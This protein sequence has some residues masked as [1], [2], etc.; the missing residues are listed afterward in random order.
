MSRISMVMFDLSGTTVKDDTGVRDCLYKAAVEFNL[1]TTPEDILFHMGTNKIHL[2]QYLI[3][4]SKGQQINFKDF[5]KTKDPQTYEE[6]VKI[7]E[8]YQEIMVKHYR[9]NV[10]EVPGASD[11]FQWCHDQNIKVATDTGFHRIVV[12]AIMDGLGW[13][14]DGLVDL[15]V[16]VEHI[17]RTNWPPRT[18]HDFL[19]HDPI[20]YPECPPSYQ[21]R[22]YAGRHVRRS[23]RW[24]SRRGWCD[25]RASPG[26]NLGEILAYTRDRKCR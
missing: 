19:R 11:V 24:G 21:D 17:P 1:Q 18:V 23:Q 6:A 3:A 20:E 13:V 7:F 15:A 25:E 14:E 4:K 10:E 12:D 26:N 8:R 9:T 22:R 2:Y 5:E 16:D